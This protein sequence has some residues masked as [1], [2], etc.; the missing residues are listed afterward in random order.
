MLGLEAFYA[1]CKKDKSQLMPYVLVMKG[2]RRNEAAMKN[3][4]WYQNR[5]GTRFDKFTK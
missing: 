5:I 3:C 2:L 1:D 4:S